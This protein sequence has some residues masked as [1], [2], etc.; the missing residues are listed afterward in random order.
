MDSGFE[1]ASAAILGRDTHEFRSRTFGP[2]ESY[3]LREHLS[4]P[5][6][7]NPQRFGL[8]LGVFAGWDD[9]PDFIPYK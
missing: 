8:E 1:T 4:D 3:K 9:Q 2:I 5:V 6:F 7:G